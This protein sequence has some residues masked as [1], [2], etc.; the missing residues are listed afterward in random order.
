MGS[1]GLRLSFLGAVLFF[2]SLA[3]LLVLPAI[4]GI[5]GI[6]AGGMAVW[7]GFIW[8]LFHYYGPSAPPS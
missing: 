7:G 1:K 8:T 4:I 5:T 2:V 3:S 6:V